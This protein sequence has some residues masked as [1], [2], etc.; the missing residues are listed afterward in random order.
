MRISGEGGRGGGREGW[1]DQEGKEIAVTSGWCGGSHTPNLA[2]V[3][4]TTGCSVGFMS[5]VG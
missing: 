2:G 5:T 3:A 1:R 4:A